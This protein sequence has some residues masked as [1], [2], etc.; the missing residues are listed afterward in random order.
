MS[1]HIFCLLGL[2][3]WGIFF[4]HL[5]LTV[6]SNFCGSLPESFVFYNTIFLLTIIWSLHQRESEEAPFMALCTNLL[7]IMF[8]IV[9]LAYYWPHTISGMKR[10]GAAMAILNLLLRPLTS[11]MLYRI[12]QDRAGS[13][14]TFGLPSSFEGIFGGPRRSPYEDIDQ[15]PQNNPSTG[16]DQEN[17]PTSSP[18]ENLF[19]T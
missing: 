5:I 13:Y 7:A 19:T 1:T 18:S 2:T 16:M 12:V 6:W 14:G 17:V 4:A 15:A 9:N 10:F 8:D 11:F 3:Q